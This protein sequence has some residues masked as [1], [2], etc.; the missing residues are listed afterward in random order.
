M[1]RVI[2]KKENFNPD[3]IADMGTQLMT[4]PEALKKI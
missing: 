2:R 4:D 3:S 1:N